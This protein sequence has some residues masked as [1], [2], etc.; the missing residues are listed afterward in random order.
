M[1]MLEY[2]RPSSPPDSLT[3]EVIPAPGHLLAS[4]EAVLRP[5]FLTFYQDSL[6]WLQIQLL[7][8]FGRQSENAPQSQLQ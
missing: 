2:K 7:I 1:T 6:I 4:A 8:I 3:R 5:V